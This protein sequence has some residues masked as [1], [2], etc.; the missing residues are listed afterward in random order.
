M[1]KQN[2]S[3]ATRNTETIIVRYGFVQSYLLLWLQNIYCILCLGKWI[4]LKRLVTERTRIFR[5]RRTKHNR[6][7]DNDLEDGNRHKR[8]FF[9]KKF[10]HFNKYFPRIFP[11][12]ASSD[13]TFFRIIRFHFDLFCKIKFQ[14]QNHLTSNCCSS[15]MQSTCKCIDF[16][17]KLH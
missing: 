13:F 17:S 16:C 11:L 2:V 6:R 3:P 12:F 9:Q 5:S 15:S 8:V 7:F 1:L 4:N 14:T 10:S